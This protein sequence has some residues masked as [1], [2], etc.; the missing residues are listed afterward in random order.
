MELAAT[1]THKKP[2]LEDIVQIFMSKSGY[3]NRPQKPFPKVS[4]IPGMKEWLE[5]EEDAADAEV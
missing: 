5:N 4:V 2:I 3:F 1:W